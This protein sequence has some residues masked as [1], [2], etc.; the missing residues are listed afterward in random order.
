MTQMDA[1]EKLSELVARFE[2]NRATYKKGT[3]NET[4]VRREFIDPFF[5]VLGWDVANKDGYAEAYKDV[6]HEDAIRVGNTTKAPD[7]CFRVGGTRK[8]F[9]EA[10]KPSIN[11]R[12][13]THPAYQLRRYAWSA[14]LPISI[15]TDFEELAVYDCRS[16]PNAGDTAGKQRILYLTF[17]QYE[18]RWQEIEDVFSKRA[19]LEG[20]FDKYELSVKG[21]RGTETVDEA[22]LKELDSWRLQLAKNISLR[23][24]TLSLENL[25]ESVQRIIDRIV[26]LRI[27]EDRGIEDYGRLRSIASKKNSYQELCRL[28]EKADS[29]YNSGLFYFTHEKERVSCVDAVTRDLRIDDAIVKGILEQIY[30]PESPYEFSVLSADILGKVYEEFLGKTIRLTKSHQAKV[31]EKPEVRKAGGVYY[32]PTNVVEHLVDRTLGNLLNDSTPQRVAQLRILDPACGS[33]SFLL[34]AYQRLLSWH[35]EWYINDGADRHAR[36]KSAAI[37]RGRRGA[38][39]LTVAKRKEILTNNIYGVDIDPQAIEVSKLSLLLKVLEGEVEW[40]KN[41]KL[42]EERALPD[43]GKN[44]QCG[45]SLVGFDFIGSL[46]TSVLAAGS[47]E[48][49]SVRSFDWK[50][51]YPKIFKSGGFDV[52]IGN[53]PYLSYA[54]RQSVQLPE[55]VRSY[56]SKIYECSGWP[57]SHSFF[58]EKAIVSLS[59]RFVA[60]IVPDQVGHLDGYASLRR[61]VGKNTNIAEVKYWGEK[62]FRGAM[63]PALTVITDKASSGDTR[64]IEHHGGESTGEL[65]PDSSWFFSPSK[66]LIDRLRRESFSVKPYVKDCGIRTTRAKQQVFELDKFRTEDLVVLEGKRIG[67]YWCSPPNKVVRPIGSLHRSSEANYDAAK[68]LIRQTAAYPIVAPHKYTKYFRNSVHA[69]LEPKGDMDVR[70]LVGLLNSKLMRFCYVSQTREAGQRT[71]PQVKIGTLAKLPMKMLNLSDEQDRRAHDDIVEHVQALLDLQ[72]SLETASRNSAAGMRQRIGALDTRLDSLVFSLYGLSAEEIV[73]V[74]ETLSNVPDSPDFPTAADHDPK[75]SVRMA[76]P[77]DQ[78]ISAVNVSTHVC[79]S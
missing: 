27:C 48:L 24:C 55:A 4:Q 36:G 32:T 53:P 19:V 25:N 58:M 7:Y 17:E 49:D 18:D 39:H 8:F 3:Y 45:N 20:A 73:L 31:E 34:V 15:L 65:A 21:K 54:G 72:E 41:I 56:F 75:G 40:L 57:T 74:S 59:R 47:E 29:K 69:L 51:S 63:T 12:T 9:V 61:F 5:E 68:F 44:L 79:P 37:F 23:N 6:V 26:F 13:D 64:I 71:F 43:L 33:G 38:W 78:R 77:E 28:F 14:K 70:Y 1:R 30:Y 62:V 76:V 10:K 67:R 52:V 35:L 22:F 2:R 66:S 50:K 11:L 46:P 42:F 16:R 60:F